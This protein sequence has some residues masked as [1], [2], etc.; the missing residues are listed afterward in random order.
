MS[1]KQISED[2]EERGRIRTPTKATKKHTTKTSSRD[3][4]TCVH[5][6]CEDWTSIKEHLMD[7]TDDRCE[8]LKEV[9]D[10]SWEVTTCSLVP[11]F[12][13]FQRNMLLVDTRVFRSILNY[14][15]SNNTSR[16]NVTESPSSFVCRTTGYKYAYEY[17]YIYK[18]LRQRLDTRWLRFTVSKQM[19]WLFT[20]V[21]STRLYASHKVLQ[22]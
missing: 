8:V 19:S 13:T 18:V 14:Q 16:G 10:A 2:V 4:R 1:Q 15:K 9:T 12:P 21:P 7:W 5:Y 17:V 22:I 6:S 11:G 20:H 3:G